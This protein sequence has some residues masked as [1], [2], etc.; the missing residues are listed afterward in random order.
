MRMKTGWTFLACG[1][2]FQGAF[3]ASAQTVEGPVENPGMRVT[4][5]AEGVHADDYLYDPASGR[6]NGDWRAVWLKPSG[7]CRKEIVLPNAPRSF[8]AWLASEGRYALFV[9]GH[10][11][12]RGPADPG[13]DG[14][15]K[16]KVREVTTLASGLCLYDFRELAPFLR[17]GTNVI[18]LTVEGNAPFLFEAE[19][20]GA[21]GAVTTVEGD[22][23]WSGG[24]VCPAPA[25]TLCPNE[26]PP[27]MEV[28]YPSVG[29][30]RPTGK[31]RVPAHPFRDGDPV[32][33][34]GDGGFA[35]KFDRVLS[36]YTALEISGGAG[37]RLRIQGNERDAPG[38]AR[39]FDVALTGGVRRVET[40]FYDS[41]T[42]VN[43][44]A[45][46]VKE[47]VEIRKVRAIFTSAPVT[48]RGAFACDDERLNAIWK[49]CRWG[50]QLCMQDYWLDSPNHQE[51]LADP[52]DYMILSQIA[53]YA[54]GSSWVARQDTRKFARILEAT[55]YQTFHTS[56][57][58]LWLQMLM[59]TYDYTGD[60]ELV[61]EC[62]PAV[63][64]LMRQF[65]GYVGKNGL[66]SEAPD[67]MFMDWVTIAG[68][69]CHHPPAVIGQGYMT[70]FYYRALLDAGR[71]AALTGDAALAADYRQWAGRVKEAFNR[72]LWCEEKGRYR[73]GRPFLSS[74]KPNA[75]LPADKDIETFSAQVSSLAV[76]YGLA[77]Q[78]RRAGVMKRVMADAPLNC[79]P[80]FMHFVLGALREAGLFET[81]GTEQMRRW[82]VFP[83]T[84]TFREMWERGDFSH[85][86]QGTPLIQLSSCVLGVTPLAPGCKR[87]AVRPL[88]CDLRWARGRVPVPEGDISVAWERSD[89]GFRLELSVP[90]GCEAE[91]SLPIG[92]FSGAVATADGRTVADAK[93]PF[94]VAPGSHHFEL[95]SSVK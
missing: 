5:D 34:D 8:R 40:P 7:V 36:A 71:V 4:V 87:F 27:R 24:T 15:W 86:W 47:S 38:G 55:H 20:V 18:A 54:F 26:T 80:Y 95:V 25:V 46:N 73:D 93:A 69:A 42:V 6:R 10:F 74:V 70:A 85:G 49:A 14:S 61:R 2:C 45:T 9:N 89:R 44:T 59:A 32:V 37:A 11:A 68:F 90:E 43:V 29:I 81:Y 88:P 63:H 77:P 67:Y 83:E 82:R 75:W 16:G 23:S 92:R 48:Y 76:L 13:H 51:P 60:L 66:V 28:P 62:A 72:E 19:A 79:Q 50:A 33:L 58:L 30:V 3:S 17:T 91:V 41:Y 94:I 12:L 65:A 52:G 84:G 21:D 1:L 31:V 35:V 39:I 57:T 22:A 53:D 64:G 78:E 56:Y